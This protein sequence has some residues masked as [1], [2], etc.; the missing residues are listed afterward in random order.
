VPFDLDKLE[1]RG[2]PAPVL[3]QVAYSAQSG[4]AQF[5]FPES[6]TGPGT[7]VYRS[8]GATGG[9]QYTVQWLDSTA[10]HNRS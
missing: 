4:S 6:S 9:G 5:A 1:A 3:E 10:K 2:T 7:L 8:G